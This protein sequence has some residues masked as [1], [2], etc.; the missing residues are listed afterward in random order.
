[1]TEYPEDFRMIE[2]EAARCAKEIDIPPCPALLARFDE[3]FNAAQPDL[4]RLAALIGTDIGLSATLIKTVNSPFYGLASKA[5]SIEHALW[6]LG[7]RVSA[8]LVGGLLLRSVFPQNT[9]STMNMFWE[10]SMH[11]AGLAAAIAAR[12]RDVDRSEAHT[13]VLFRDCGMLVMLRKYPQYAGIIEQSTR[14]PGAQ[15]TRLEDAR[16]QFNHARVASALARSWFLS[17]PLCAAILYHHDFA[18]VEKSALA[19]QLPNPK[20]V[21]FGLLAEQIAA[22]HAKQGLCPDWIDAEQF[23]LATLGIGADDIVELADELLGVAA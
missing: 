2:R 15:L 18:L 19:A 3:E 14:T 7:L 12:L 1:M 6:I 20:L 5:T 13:Y 4:R 11:I 16:F 9:N 23:V 17:E 22:L 21:A 10:R 8:N